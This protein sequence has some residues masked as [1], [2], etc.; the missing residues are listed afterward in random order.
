VVKRVLADRGALKPGA[1]VSAQAI[2]G[3]IS[4]LSASQTTVRAVT[5]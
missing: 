5:P 4:I 3:A 1:E 2:R